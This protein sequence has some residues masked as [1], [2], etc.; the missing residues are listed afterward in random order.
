MREYPIIESA[1]YCCVAASLEAMLKRHNFNDVTQ[2]DVANFIGVVAYESDRGELPKGLT[3][4]SYT[5][6]VDQI[7]MHLREN[8]LS[9]LFSHFNLPFKETFINWNE[10]SD[11]N[12]DGILQAIPD[13]DD[14]LLLF[15]FGWLYGEEK[16]RGVGHSGLFVSIDTSSIITYMN[17]GP[18]FIGIGHFASEDF[19]T[20]I[21]AKHGGISIIRKVE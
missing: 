2:Y 10:L 8:S 19:V 9:D 1:P 4:I 7:G 20:A 12:I 6:D 5:N 13:E 11:W 15:D 16:N 21:R 3:N 17:P 18:R 14:A